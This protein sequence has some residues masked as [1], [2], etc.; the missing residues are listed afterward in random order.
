VSLD[1]RDA[2][3]PSLICTSR[4]EN[5]FKVFTLEGKFLRR[6]DLPG[7]YVCRA[8]VNEKNIYAGVCWSKDASGKRNPNSGFITILDERNTVVSNP[9]GMAPVYKANVLQPTLQAPAPSFQHG[10]D[11]CVDDDK[12]LY[13]CQW[14]AN[15]TPPVKLTRVV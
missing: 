8:V 13:V 7:M 3:N 4:E 6:I 12:N 10:H 9:G 5:C 15:Y 14:R 11:V 1:L 2:A